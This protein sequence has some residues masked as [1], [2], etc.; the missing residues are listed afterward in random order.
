MPKNPQRLSWTR[1]GRLRPDRC[2]P[3]L[4]AAGCHPG[5]PLCCWMRARRPDKYGVCWCSAYPFPHRY[6]SGYCGH[7]ERMAAE[8]AAYERRRSVEFSPADGEGD[9]PSEDPPF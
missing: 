6:G 3:D 2:R 1:D 7:P 8:Q 5:R 9:D 4:H